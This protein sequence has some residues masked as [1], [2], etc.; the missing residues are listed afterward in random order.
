[1]GALG[2]VLSAFPPGWLE[3]DDQSKATAEER[4]WRLWLKADRCKDTGRFARARELLTQAS[5]IAE[6]AGWTPENAPV[7]YAELAALSA[8]LLQDDGEPAQAYQE[9]DWAL[10]AWMYLGSVLQPHDDSSPNVTRAVL[11]PA[12]AMVA[13]LVGPE[14]LAALARAAGGTVFEVAVSTWLIDR[15]V[16]ELSEIAARTVTL[17]AEA[18][19][20]SDARRLANDLLASFNRWDFPTWNPVLVEIGMHKALGSAASNAR[21]FTRALG[22]ADDALTL[23]ARLPRG[24][25]RSRE[26]AQLRSNRARAL[27][28]LRR[29]A[30]AVSDFEWAAATLES[31]GDTT[32][33]LRVRTGLMAARAEAGH[34]VD[35]SV[36]RQLLA[37]LESEVARLDRPDGALMEDLE[38]IR[39]LHLSLL[40]EDAGADLEEVV[41]LI[42]EIRGDR[43][44][45]RDGRDYPDPVVARLCRASTLLGSRLE[46][47]PDTLLLV[48]EPGV[49]IEGRRWPLFLTISSGHEAEK[50]RWRVA[51]SNETAADALTALQRAAAAERAKLVTGEIAVHSAPSEALIHD[52]TRAWSTL[53]ADVRGAILK[54]RTVVYLPSSFAGLDTIPLELLRHEG[55]WLGATHVVVRCPSFQYLEELV[56]PNS[57]RWSD[58]DRAMVAQAAPDAE[59]GVLAEAEADVRIA[60]RA[61]T[62]LGLRAEHLELSQPA[63][64]VGLF[65]ERS[66][67]HYIGHG[68]AD[69]LGEF[70]RLSAESAVS[71]T[72]LPDADSARVPFVF[73]NACLLGR[74]R[75][76]EGGRQRGWA[77]ALLERG[78]PGVVGALDS[79][80]DNACP[81]VAAAFYRCVWKAPVGEGMRQA[82][83][84]LDAQG[85]NPAVWA[86]YVLHG[87]PNAAISRAL[88]RGPRGTGDLTARW[89][90]HLT[91]F[92]ATGRPDHRDALVGAI[93]ADPVLHQV[94]AAHDTVMAWVEGG[95]A[96]G[97]ALNEA[98]LA[99]AVDELLEVDPEGA[100]V[101]RILLAIERPPG[102]GSEF[103][104]AY[105]VASALDDDY[106]M[107]HLIGRYSQYLETWYPGHRAEYRETVEALLRSV[108]TDGAALAPVLTQ[109]KACS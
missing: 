97:G 38:A 109:L 43:P 52:A 81:L 56:S 30:D 78:A 11:T 37:D 103:R 89:P 40:A 19:S 2:E 49:S 84:R 98:P 7:W 86:A 53:P 23:A 14:R 77:L 69:E 48:L 3:A 8:E 33:A 75:H 18:L 74:V 101:C 9:S 22:L 91:R 107:L 5:D 21:H 42:E 44:I 55:G 82:R 64:A 94:R 46:T 83:A 67:V 68:Y 24:S 10:Q 96:S 85:I 99:R 6:M 57:R 32:D 87:D 29:P 17:T 45:M 60:M 88:P 61:A 71:A 106:A 27:F 16:P 15:L 13:V 50:V 65:S 108:G 58:D 34:A 73:F 28:G 105:L 41:G 26:E 63:D 72:A 35:T 95:A 54:A 66:L 4:V 92:L 47:L 59:L 70:L 36:V 76:L 104:T 93:G 100:A 25:Q 31:I 80:P 51:V 12:A 20:Y 39:R 102:D 1:M 62:L 90:A 79:V